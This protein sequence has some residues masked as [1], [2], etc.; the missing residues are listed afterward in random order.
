MRLDHAR[1]AGVRVLLLLFLGGPAAVAAEPVGTRW[2][3]AGAA[4]VP[5]GGQQAAHA[6]RGAGHSAVARRHRRDAPDSLV[7]VNTASAAALQALKGVGEKKARAI[8][9]Y[10][11]A[12]GAFASLDDFDDVPGIGPALIEANRERIL[13]R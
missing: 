8:V 3:P 11:K 13:F 12:H 1:G 7:N 5:A 9:A 2:S 10:R 4:A 6:R